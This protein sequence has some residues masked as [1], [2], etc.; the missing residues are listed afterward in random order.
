MRPRTEIQKRVWKI[1]EGLDRRR[2]E[3]TDAQR[4]WISRHAFDGD[5]YQTGKHLR[6][7]RCGHLVGKDEDRC[8]HCGNVRRDVYSRRCRR[9]YEYVGIVGVCGEYQ[10]VSI[11]EVVRSI[12][13]DGIRTGMEIVAE[14]WIDRD[15]R[16]AVVARTLSPFGGTFCWESEMM[17][18]SNTYNG[19]SRGWYGNKE[20]YM[21]YSRVYPKMRLLPFFRSRGVSLVEPVVGDIV[22][23]LTNV[24]KDNLLE[25]MLKVG[26]GKLAMYYLEGYSIKEHI[27]KLAVR[28][29]YEPEDYRTW[30]DYIY[31]LETLHMDTHNPKVLMPENLMEAHLRTSERLMRK[32]R[33][34]MEERERE[35]RLDLVAKAELNEEKYIEKKG[36]YLGIRFS[37]DGIDFHVLQSPL[38]FLEEGEAMHH[39][40]A[41]YW[42]HDNSL[43]LSARDGSGKRV[44]TVEV[45]LTTFSIVQSQGP[46]NRPTEWHESIM[47][48]VKRN[49]KLIKGA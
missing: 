18:K 45:N 2:K 14:N 7:C 26:L 34:D 41:S 48:T 36:K 24:P 13:R 4:K 27:W 28:Y 12:G 17:I 29:R 20:E 10:R 37:G 9:Y 44:E 43:V 40:V 35:R 3:L 33:K 25:T 30:R 21:R 16:R 42:S 19:N 11:V 31:E 1:Y 46:C 15:G 6:C 5:F 47:E 8:P 49:M 23:V 32:R 22:S 39:C 38:E